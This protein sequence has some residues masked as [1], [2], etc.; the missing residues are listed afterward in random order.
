MYEIEDFLCNMNVSF[1][2]RRYF[3]V[4]HNICGKSFLGIEKLMWSLWALG[5]SLEL[6]AILSHVLSVRL[7][8]SRRE[9]YEQDLE[10][11]EN[12]LTRADI[13]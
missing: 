11:Q 9:K 1:V 6:I 10:D 5:I 2:E 12:G 4:K 8:G 3:E 13:Y 7:S